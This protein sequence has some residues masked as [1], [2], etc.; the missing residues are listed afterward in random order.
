[1]ALIPVANCSNEAAAGATAPSAQ[2]GAWFSPFQERSKGGQQSGDN[3]LG[4]SGGGVDSVGLDG[5]GDVDEILVDHG[6]EGS[7][8]ALGKVAEDLVESVDV[9]ATVVGGQRDA[10]KENA[11]MCT[12]E[13]GENGVEVAARLVRGKATQP[14]VSAKLDDDDSRMQSQHRTETGSRIFC[15]GA[16]CAQIRYLVVVAALVEIS[17]QSVGEGFAGV[18]AVPCGDAVAVAD[19]YGQVGGKQQR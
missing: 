14:V 5:A 12:L 11:R 16:A 19:D 1:M 4:T 13:R 18:K 15:C 7:V 17:L 2:V 9:V 8:V 3:D 6:D 10:G